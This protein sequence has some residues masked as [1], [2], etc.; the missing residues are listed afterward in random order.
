MPA[1]GMT[2]TAQWDIGKFN[3]IYKNAGETVYNIDVVCGDPIKH[4][5]VTDSQGRTFIGWREQGK[6]GLFTQ[7]VMPGYSFVL[8][9]VWGYTITFVDDNG[10][11]LKRVA[12][13]PGAAVVAPEIPQRTGTTIIGW[14]NTITTMPNRDVTVKAV[15][16]YN[17]YTI[18]YMNGDKVYKQETYHYGDKIQPV[19]PPKKWFKAFEGWD[20]EIPETM[21]DFDIEVNAVWSNNTNFVKAISAIFTAIINFITTLIGRLA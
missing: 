2:L 14:D 4:P 21:P 7:T 15:R 1:G 19:D 8:E 16:V 5:T 18:T 17:E 10:V 3:I 11:I 13:E 6:T 12:L 9:A 20:S